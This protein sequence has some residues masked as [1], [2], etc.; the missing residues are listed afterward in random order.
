MAITKEK[1]QEIIQEIRENIVNQHVMFFVNF[2]GMKGNDCSA[3]RKDLFQ[4]NAKIMVAKKTLAKIAFQK[5]GIDFD[6]LTLE[7]EVGF[8][9]GFGDIASVA[10][11]V[12]RFDKT[13]KIVILGGVCEGKIIT[14]SEAKDIANLPTREELLGKL[15]GT[16]AAPIGGF[17]QVL[18]GNTKGLI[19]VLAKIKQ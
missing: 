16:V 10:K 8:V 6:P 7:K 15:V 9:F 19:T 2:K 3:F 13:E 17:L 18:Q 4:N 14:E 1:K 5:E 12:C 11:A